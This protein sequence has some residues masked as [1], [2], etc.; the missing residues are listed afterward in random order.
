MASSPA[1]VMSFYGC[2]S[3]DALNKL[4]IFREA[5]Q[6]RG[7]RG[8]GE[9]MTRE[10]SSSFETF[11]VRRTNLECA[12]DVWGW[13]DRSD[14]D[15][16][17]CL[18]DD[19]A[20]LKGFLADGVIKCVHFCVGPRYRR[21]GIPLRKPGF[22]LGIE[23]FVAIELIRKKGLSADAKSARAI[24]EFV[25]ENWEALTQDKKL[26]SV[27]SKDRRKFLGLVKRSSS[28]PGLDEIVRLGL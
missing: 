6:E 2:S 23:S 11:S 5:A 4:S 15:D 27:T 22:R 14:S 13:I 26:V 19:A 24:D 25:R 9:E 10:T 17:V 28:I 3:E 20:F 21:F 18:E 8:R 7:F 16:G 1:S 12:V